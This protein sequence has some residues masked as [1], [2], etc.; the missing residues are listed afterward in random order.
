MSSGGDGVTHHFVAF[1]FQF[2]HVDPV[3]VDRPGAV[4]DDAGLDQ[5]LDQH[6][7]DIGG[8]FHVFTPVFIGEDLLAGVPDPFPIK[9]EGAV[10]VP[11]L[12]NV[13]EIEENGFKAACG[14]VL[15]PGMFGYSWVRT[16]QSRELMADILGSL[17][18]FDIEIEG[19]RTETGP[20]VQMK[21]KGF[22]ADASI[23]EL[24]VNTEVDLSERI[25]LLGRLSC[26]SFALF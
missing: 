18:A 8:A 9:S 15:D 25:M 14:P 22:E 17:A 6:P 3:G 26:S 1:T 4:G 12:G 24:A 2:T 10:D 13:Q 21:V 11:L 16:G 23:L 19:L 20:G 7:E 5:G